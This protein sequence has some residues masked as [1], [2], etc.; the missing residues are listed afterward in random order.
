MNREIT[1]IWGAQLVELIVWEGQGRL[2]RGVG[3]EI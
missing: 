2:F 3:T 1:N